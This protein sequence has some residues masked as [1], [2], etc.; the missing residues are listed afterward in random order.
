MLN[1]A[2]IE[3]NTAPVQFLASF[4][5]RR[6]PEPDTGPAFIALSHAVEPSDPSFCRVSSLHRLSWGQKGHPFVHGP[7]S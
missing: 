3:R 6:V 5:S 1:T 4:D 7:L 2:D